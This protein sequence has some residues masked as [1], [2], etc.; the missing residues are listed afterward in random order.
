MGEGGVV[1]SMDGKSMSRS[2]QATIYPRQ[3]EGAHTH[4]TTK[5][6]SSAV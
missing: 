4:A 5:Q 2:P 1:G 3:N 6:R